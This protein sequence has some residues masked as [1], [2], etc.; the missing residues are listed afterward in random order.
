MKVKSDLL[1]CENVFIVSSDNW[2][3]LVNFASSSKKIT[4]FSKRVETE[5]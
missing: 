2:N 1:T 4:V 5:S 3:G